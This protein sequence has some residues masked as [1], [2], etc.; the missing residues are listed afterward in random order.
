MS[1]IDSVLQ[2][3]W[4]EAIKALW[5]NPVSRRNRAMHYSVGKYSSG[6]SHL[7]R[8]ALAPGLP[9]ED[10]GVDSDGTTVLKVVQ[11]VGS[12][13]KF[14]LATQIVEGNKKLSRKKNKGR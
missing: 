11:D 13:K 2:A 12:F 10:A 1:R 6:L 9:T 8:Q 14:G 3:P 4:N 5:G 7:A